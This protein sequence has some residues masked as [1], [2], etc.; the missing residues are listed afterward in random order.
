MEKYKYY[1]I[2][3]FGKKSHLFQ[4]CGSMKESICVPFNDERLYDLPLCLKCEKKAELY[5]K[6]STTSKTSWN[7][8]VDALKNINVDSSFENRKKI[9]KI[10]GISNYE[11]TQQQNTALLNK[12]KEGKLKLPEEED[13]SGS[14]STSPSLNKSPHEM[15]QKIKNSD[16]FGEKRDA[17]FI[18]GNILVNNK[19]ETAFIAGLLA[20]IKHE[21]NFGI[22][23]SPFYK[24]KPKPNYLKIMDEKYNYSQKY[25]GKYV[26]NLSLKELKI[27]CDKLKKD[28]WQKGKFGLIIIQWNGERTSILVDLYLAEVNNADKINLE[29]VISAEGKM[30]IKELNNQY[31]SIY[32]NWKKD[33]GNNLNTE[34]AAFD[35]ASKICIQY[36]IPSQKENKAIERG[37]T[38]REIYRVMTS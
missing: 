33:N 12:I 8:I 35:A 15:I 22:F 14:I 27:M 19:Y 1:Y 25:S 38:A 29:Q 20:N 24:T 7:S 18:I 2:S 21:G 4:T 11:G 9:A 6:Q 36:E 37:N 10:N 16:K 5:Y 26:Y 17:L 32:A 28:K 23:E 13:D 30:M 3:K 34:N 31:K